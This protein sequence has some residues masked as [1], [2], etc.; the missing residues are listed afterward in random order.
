MQPRA[1]DE[2]TYSVEA[3][4]HIAR[5]LV[6]DIHETVLAH[7]GASSL[8]AKRRPP[9]GRLCHAR[10]LGEL[11]RRAAEL[12]WV[13]ERLVTTATTHVATG[14]EHSTRGRTERASARTRRIASNAVAG[15]DTTLSMC[16]AREKQLSTLLI[17]G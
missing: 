2:E 3:L 4:Q 16:A 5:R 11:M 13:R 8:D 14:G 9:V 10:R 1:G 7:E 15:I 6:E 12:Q 17:P